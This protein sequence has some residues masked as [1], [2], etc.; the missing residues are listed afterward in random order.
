M[1]SFLQIAAGKTFPTQPVELLDYILARGDEPCGPTVPGSILGM[2]AFFENIGGRP[3]S[4]QLANHPMITAFVSDLKLELVTGAPKTK[5]KAHQHLLAVVKSWELRVTDA[6]LPLWHRLHAWTELIAIW[7]SFRTSD[8]SGIPAMSLRRLDDGIEGS[9]M[10]SKTTGAGKRV[11][12]M[13][14]F[15]S[16]GAWLLRP[17]WLSGGW[18]LYE[19]SRSALPFL[20]PL[21]LEGYMGLSVREPSFLQHVV[22]SRKLLAETLNV[23][24]APTSE[25]EGFD[26]WASYQHEALPLLVPGA[27][28][29]WSGHSKRA[30]LP[31]W[32]AAL[33]FPKD[34]RDR[35]GR[36]RPEDSDEY[37]RVSRQLILEL[38]AD[39][40][41]QLRTCGRK[42][43]VFESQVIEDLIQFCSERG[44]PLVD[45]TAMV[46]RLISLRS[47]G[48]TLPADDPASLSELWHEG[49]QAPSIDEELEQQDTDRLPV[50]SLGSWVVSQTK[51]GSF[52]TLHQVGKCWRRPGLHFSRYVLL[53]AGEIEAGTAKYNRVCVDCFPVGLEQMLKDDSSTDSSSS[54]SS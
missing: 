12:E 54:S 13:R 7:A 11:G 29:F 43:L 3:V 49:E 6:A 52:E 32:A 22:A 48:N 4:E 51:G 20:I 1:K 45:T 30:T 27:Q 23:A 25:A 2:V 33:H 41:R 28:N 9:I 31:T 15:V 39:V 35:L 21:P 16:D 8:V 34:V 44:T 19:A 50:L 47:L 53:D 38:Q 42:D 10:L 18:E 24:L 14:F 26:V 17:G 37:V 40:A 46:E 5:R 36:W